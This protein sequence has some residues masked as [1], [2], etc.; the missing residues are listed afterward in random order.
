MHALFLINVLFVCPHVGDRYFFNGVVLYSI[1]I[2]K[3]GFTHTH[4]MIYPT[5]LVEDYLTV[6]EKT[7]S[8]RGQKV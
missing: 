3:G 4:T 1:D 7:R 8:Q 2:I 5:C 6:N